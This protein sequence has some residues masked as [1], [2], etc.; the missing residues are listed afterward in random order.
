[1]N[2]LDLAYCSE[3]VMPKDP[4]NNLAIGIHYYSPFEFIFI[5]NY[6]MTWYDENVIE[7]YYSSPKKWCSSAEYNE[8]IVNFE[9]MKKYFVNK[10]IL[11]ILKEIESIREYLYSLFS[12]CWL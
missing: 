4:S 7:Y 11:V 3:Y 2:D 1:M 8:M 12:V 5:Y 9:I 10:E 6:E